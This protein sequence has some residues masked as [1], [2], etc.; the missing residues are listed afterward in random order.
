MR[1]CVVSK[2]DFGGAASPQQLQDRPAAGD[3]RQG[4]NQPPCCRAC[5]LFHPSVRLLNQR[6]AR[7][8]CKLPAEAIPLLGQML[9]HP[10]LQ[11]WAAFVKPLQG[12]ITSRAVRPA[13]KGLAFEP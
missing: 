9:F 1:Q 6:L 3:N 8:R 4:W 2:L 13:Y 7:W 10:M 12:S 11:K 5:H